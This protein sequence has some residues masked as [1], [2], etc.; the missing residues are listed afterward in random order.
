MSDEFSRIYSKWKTNTYS[1]LVY[2]LVK[3]S[4]CPLLDGNE[5]ME[6]TCL[7]VVS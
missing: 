7:W 4:Y 1:I 2:I 3:K 6:S 5:S